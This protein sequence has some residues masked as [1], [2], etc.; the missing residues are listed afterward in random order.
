MIAVVAECW[1][2]A[3][4]FEK[5]YFGCVERICQRDDWSGDSSLGW[6]VVGFEG[7]CGFTIWSDQKPFG[8][9][10]TQN[11]FPISAC[12][13]DFVRLKFPSFWPVLVVIMTTSRR[14]RKKLSRFLF[15]PQ[16]LLTSSLGIIEGGR[17]GVSFWAPKPGHSLLTNV[18][19]SEP[20]FD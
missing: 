8:T 20:S 10:C 6:F 11:W 19:I 13:V 16:V 18:T 9:D 2:V 3:S 17:V 7:T 14:E 4:I 15:E 1:R 12:E 5:R